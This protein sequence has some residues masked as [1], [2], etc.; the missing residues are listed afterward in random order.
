MRI[1]FIDSIIE[2]EI[3]CLSVL[4]SFYIKS[5]VIWLYSQFPFKTI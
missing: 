2:G 5:T 3:I 4:L 1:G